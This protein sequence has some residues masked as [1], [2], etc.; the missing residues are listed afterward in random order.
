MQRRAQHMYSFS[1]P[2]STGFP[3][4]DVSG[5]NGVNGVIGGMGA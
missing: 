4:S 1:L 3:V 2:A 5:V